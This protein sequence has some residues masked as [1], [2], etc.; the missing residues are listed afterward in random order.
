MSARR[1][2]L[3]I[4]VHEMW[5]IDKYRWETCTATAN[6]Y[7]LREERATAIEYF[8]RY[9]RDNIQ[10]SSHSTVSLQLC[11]HQCCKKKLNGI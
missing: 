3:A 10:L 7:S 11:Q 8:E 5:K 9:V 1:P 6:Y 2:E 4:L